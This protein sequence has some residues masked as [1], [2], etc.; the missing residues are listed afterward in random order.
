MKI[1]V[2][3]ICHHANAAT[4]LTCSACGTTPREYS[5]TGKAARISQDDNGPRLIDA[6]VAQG[7]ERLTD[8]RGRKLYFRTVPADYFAF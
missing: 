4:R 1:Y 5:I 6:V 3:E 2:C 8:R 7:A